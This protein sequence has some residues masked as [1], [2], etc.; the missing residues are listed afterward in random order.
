MVR[1][2][3]EREKSRLLEEQTPDDC[4]EW[5]QADR[6]DLVERSRK[7]GGTAREK[8]KKNILYLIGSKDPGGAEKVLVELASNFQL[9]GYDVTVGHLGN[10]WLTNE[11]MK[12]NIHNICFNFSKFYYSHKTEWLFILNLA[13]FIR[14]HAFDLIHAHLFGMILYSSIAGK[15]LKIPVLGTIHDKYYFMEREHRRIAYRII[16]MLGCRL[17]SVSKDIRDNLSQKWGMKAEEIEV[18]YNGIDPEDFDVSLD[19]N[20]KRREVGL[21]GED[22]IVI[23][24]GRLVHMKG[25][26]IL[27]RAATN[28]V[29]QNKRVKFLIV[30]DGPEKEELKQLAEGEGI[31]ESVIFAGHRDDV[32]ELLLISDIFA[33]TSHTEGLSCTV[34]EALGAGLPVVVTDVGG[35]KEIIN[36]GNEG[37]LVPTTNQTVLEERILALAEND[38]LRTEKAEN[39]KGT[40]EKFSSKFMISKYEQ[41]YLNLLNPRHN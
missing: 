1:K 20:A 12:H 35:N 4:S 38:K 31:S 40:A 9:R 27:I 34:I 17:V 6:R 33:Q 28:I 19:R 21:N 8:T 2:F 25:H 22:V 23:S 16:Q 15:I 7:V 36:N 41:L 26:S 14:A 37:Y 13:K 3:F 30:G 10:P 24:V 18:L 11:L 5:L 32:P 29:R 39:A